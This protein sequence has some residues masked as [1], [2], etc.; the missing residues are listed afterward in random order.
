MSELERLKKPMPE[1][2]KTVEVVR[3]VVREIPV[4]GQED[5]IYRGD[6]ALKEKV[7]TIE[8]RGN[9]KVDSA[10]GDFVCCIPL[11]L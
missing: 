9:I 10:T 5:A 11:C 1:Q 3:E 7:Q 4:Q 8:S 2:V 6:M